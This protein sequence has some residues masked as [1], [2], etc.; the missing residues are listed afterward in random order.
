MN[1][2]RAYPNNN[3]SKAVYTDDIFITADLPTFVYWNGNTRNTPF[4]AGLT[5]CQEGF[6]FRYGAWAD[7][8]TVVC[9]VK[10]DSTMWIWSKSRNAWV[11]YAAKSDL[12]AS[13]SNPYVVTLQNTINGSLFSSAQY[14]SRRTEGGTGAAAYGFENIGVNSGALYL[15]PSDYKLHFINYEGKKFVINWTAES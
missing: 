15:D 2:L 3:L 14:R 1:K 5:E 13:Q 6:A 12:A 9:F 4:K 10:N 7:Y 8:M 11:E